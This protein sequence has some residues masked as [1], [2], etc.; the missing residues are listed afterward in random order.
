MTKTVG[1]SDIA[2]YVPSNAMDVAYLAA[3]RT[4][5]QP[6]LGTHLERAIATTGQRS[7]RFPCPWED[8]ATMAAEAARTL[9]LSNPMT[10]LAGLRYLAAGTETG[11]DHAKPISA[12]VQGMLLQAGLPIGTSHSSFQVQHACAG[13]TLGLLSVAALLGLGAVPGEFGLVTCSDVARYESHTTAEITQGAGAA[14]LLVEGA[15]K[16]LELDVGTAG[17]YSSDADDF[18]R[19]LG[20]TVARVKGAHSLKCYSQSLEAAF[21]DHCRRRGEDP[22]RVLEST[23]L[24]VL[25]TPFRNL[26]ELVMQR[27]LGRVTGSSAEAGRE[28]LRRRGL[29][30]A[31]APVAVVGNTYTAS[32][33]LCLASLLAQRHREEGQGIVGRSI[34]M[35]SYG[36]GNT[37]VVA[38]ARVA[39]GAPEVIGRWRLERYL[40]ARTETGW[41]EYCRWIEDGVE[42]GI[43][44]V[45][46]SPNSHPNC[47]FLRRIR[48][49]GY[50]E[51]GY[52]PPGASQASRQAVGAHASACPADHPR[53]P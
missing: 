12:Y 35:A 26:P 39:A 38:S 46:E 48:P 53:W 34:L 9:V 37:M 43:A 3:M 47:Y 5:E 19:P 13:G 31:T 18:F 23:D 11:L 32:L 30:A 14:A 10:D 22:V 41:E 50:R 45:T 29:Y 2:L 52:R 1:I 40:E 20:S 15:P 25:H 7:L 16:L 49:D 21:L 17:L 4:R 33:Y 51:Y 6:E 42:G 27:L 8:A 24:V 44:E 36:S 28:F